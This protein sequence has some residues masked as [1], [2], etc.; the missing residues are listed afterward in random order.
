[1]LP[2]LPK[3]RDPKH[4]WLNYVAVFYAF[5]LD[6]IGW[7]LLYYNNNNNN[8]MISSS[9]SIRIVVG[10]ILSFH[11]RIIA[12]YLIHEA[13]HANI[14]IQ[15]KYNRY[16]GITCLWLAGCPYGDFTHIKWMHMSHHNDR[17]DTV[18]FNY[19]DFLKRNRWLCQLVLLLDFSFIPAVETLMHLRTAF[20]FLKVMPLPSNGNNNKKKDS[21]M[22]ITSTTRHQSSFVGTTIML[23]FYYV[24]WCKS[25]YLVVQYLC[26]GALVLQY[27][28]FNDAFHHTY[29][30]IVMKD[31]ITPGPGSRTLQYEE[32]NTYSNLISTQYPIWNLLSLNFGYHNAHHTKAMVPWYDLPQYHDAL[33]GRSSGTTT[34]TTG[35]SGNPST[36]FWTYPQ[37]L[38]MKDLIHAFYRYRVRR[39]LDDDYGYVGPVPGDP[40]R[41]EHFVGALGVSF[42]TV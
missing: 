31:Y 5:I 20:Y 28:S 18:E 23:I 16:F 25:P 11:G 39:V 27:L 7:F 41:A 14:Y 1:M 26:M 17:A 4:G 24:L 30:G 9:S 8:S 35:T 10:I 37:L 21:R 15:P 13:A 32:D 22:I 19:K 40:K 2:P 42:L 29:E 33:Y 6:F 38:P 12:S 36:E 34:T 3:L